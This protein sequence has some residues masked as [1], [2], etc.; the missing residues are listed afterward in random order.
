MKN[1][2]WCSNGVVMVYNTCYQFG[3]CKGFEDFCTINGKPTT[4]IKR[5][6]MSGRKM[7]ENLDFMQVSAIFETCINPHKSAYYTTK[8]V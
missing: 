7:L 3:I 8:M 1:T 4:C 2:K 6:R 5:R